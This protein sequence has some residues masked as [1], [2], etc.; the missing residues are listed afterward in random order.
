MNT[1]HMIL[2]WMLDQMGT[3]RGVFAVACDTTVEKY[4]TYCYFSGRC[5]F[6][7]P[8]LDLASNPATYKVYNFRLGM[9]REEI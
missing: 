3:I 9:N 8:P 5:E 1:H 7:R 6:N 4:L 2:D